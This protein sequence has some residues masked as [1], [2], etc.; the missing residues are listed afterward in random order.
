MQVGHAEPRPGSPD[1]RH[2]PRPAGP[3]RARRRPHPGPGGAV[4]AGRGIVLAVVDPGVGTDRR[5]VAVEVEHGILLGPDNGLLAPAVAIL[6]G[7]QRVVSLTST[8]HQLPVAGSDVRRAR[9]PRSRRR[10]PRCGR[11]PVGVGR[12]RGRGRG[13]SRARVAAPARRGWRDPRRGVVDRSVRQLPAQHRPDELRRARRRARGADRGPLRRAGAVG[14]DGCTRT[15]TPSRRSSCCSSIRTAWRRSPSTVAR[16]PPNA[17]SHRGRPS[18]WCHP[19]RRCRGATRS[20]RSDAPRYDDRRCR[21]AL[22]HPGGGVRPVRSATRPVT[23]GGSAARSPRPTGTWAPGRFLPACAPTHSAWY[24]ITQ[25][26]RAARSI[27]SRDSGFRSVG[28]GAAGAA[29]SWGGAR[30]KASQPAPSTTPTAGAPDLLLGAVASSGSAATVGGAAAAASGAVALRPLPAPLDVASVC[31]RRGGTFRLCVSPSV[32]PTSWPT[33]TWSW[34]GVD[35]PVS[36]R[37]SRPP[38]AAPALVLCE[39]YGFLG[40]NLTVAKVGTICGLYVGGDG[41]EFEFVVGGIAR[42]IAEALA[43]D[44][45]GVGPVPFKETAVFLYVPWAVKRLADHL[46]TEE[47]RLEVLLHSL[48]ADVVVDDGTLRAIVACDQARPMRGHGEGLRRLHRRRRPRH[49]RRRPHRARAAR[50]A[51]VRVDAVRHAARRRVPR[52]PRCPNSET[53]SAS[54]ARTF[55]ATGAPSS[56]RSAPASSSAR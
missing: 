35:R 48:V 44:G 5:L 47:D 4:P 37:R 3:R 25:G 54:T 18:R 43:R 31:R 28:A 10:P 8:E 24:K 56:R 26:A 7:A 11:R 9:R 30:G 29:L 34:P 12:R 14:G 32:R 21:A 53:S 17:R 42:E 49:V 45:A 2:H 38:A 23:S 55:R 39:R 15:P 6:G 51:P 1:H 40:G 16:P 22:H 13:W 52:W 33:P 19:A 46:V 36:A 20:R 27:V 50:L 41:G